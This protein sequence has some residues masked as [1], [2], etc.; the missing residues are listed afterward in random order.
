MNP[1]LIAVICSLPE[2]GILAFFA[3]YWIREARRSAAHRERM[4]NQYAEFVHELKKS[5]RKDGAK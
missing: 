4:E 3:W 2:F 5:V 1:I